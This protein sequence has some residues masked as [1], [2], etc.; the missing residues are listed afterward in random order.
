MQFGLMNPDEIALLSVA[1][2]KSTQIY[3]HET[4]LPNFNA[5]ND[6]RMGSM[7]REITCV[8]CRADPTVCPG[9][10]GHIALNAPV[11]QAGT[12]PYV[13]KFLR[14]VCFNCSKLLAPRGDT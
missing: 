4:F 8:T 14:C 11:F 9:H 3:D 7:E 12:L 10:V 5:V 2:I 6:P 13:I 1:E